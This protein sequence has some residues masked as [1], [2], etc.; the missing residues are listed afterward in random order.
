MPG[1]QK[2]STAARE[3]PM[4]SARTLVFAVSG[5][6]FASLPVCGQDLSRYRD[7][8]LGSTAASVAKASGLTA[9]DVK[10]I[11][12]RP[13]VIQE[14][15]WR[16]QQRSFGAT[17]QTDPVKEVVFSFY[18]DQ[19]FLVIVDYDRQ[20][21]E[22]LT[23]ADLIEL[24]T[25]AYGPPALRATSLPIGA[26]LASREADMVIARW[27][28]AESTLTLLRGTYPTSVRLVLALTRVETLASTA[29]AEAV[30]QD[31]LEAPQRESDR[32]TRV[33]EDAR[34]AVEKARAVNR[35]AFKP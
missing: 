3:I 28:G 11:H 25:A 34:V 33:A 27:A 31:A 21:V 12:Q 30:Q 13:A 23:D 26:P 18:N 17:A 9:G 15:K 4:V 5:L 35:V 20:R 29:A 8:A 16:P 19:L 2:L 7:F 22:G 32:R 1:V 6:V 10:V 24:M 14:L